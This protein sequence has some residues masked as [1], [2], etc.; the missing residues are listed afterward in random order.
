LLLLGT[1]GH[2]ALVDTLRTAMAVADPALAAVA[3]LAF[4]KI[5]GV[6]VSSPQRVEVVLEEGGPPSDLFVPDV[7][8]ASTQ[9][10]NLQ[11]IYA[12]STRICRGHDL[13]NRV[14]DD[15][16]AELDM[17]SRFEVRLRGRFYGTWQGHLRDLGAI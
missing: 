7:E 9:W 1:Y 13:S 15:I 11:S 8:K 14:S 17:E 5:T 10:A 2:P 6:D 12:G 16:F 3:G 4:T